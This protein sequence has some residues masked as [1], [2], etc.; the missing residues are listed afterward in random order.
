MYNNLA[1]QAYQ[2]ASQ[3][4]ANPRELEANL[5]MKA[6]QRLQMLVDNWDD[7]GK[8]ELDDALTYN[9]RLWTILVTSATSADSALPQPV[10]QNIANLALFIFKHSITVLANPHQD[11]LAT[12]IQINR[13]IAEG[14]RGM[15]P[16]EA[17]V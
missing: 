9:R 15:I 8:Y 14:L 10:Q 2:K 17:G 6:A 4:T 16:A 12:L 1:A 13:N 5:L 7:K 3:A 11:R